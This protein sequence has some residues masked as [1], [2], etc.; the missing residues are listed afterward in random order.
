MN[1]VLF[2]WTTVTTD[3]TSRGFKGAN[4]APPKN[5]Y[6]MYIIFID[7]VILKPHKNIIIDYS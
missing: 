3:Y 5:I 2:G 4:V 6:T 1:H 7:L